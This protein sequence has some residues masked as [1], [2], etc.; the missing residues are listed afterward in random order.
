MIVHAS[1]VR[2]LVDCGRPESWTI[3]ARINAYNARHPGR[4]EGV[5]ASIFFIN[6]FSKQHHRTQ[7]RNTT[8]KWAPSIRNLS[9]SVF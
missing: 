8:A 4:G 2:V 9:Q 3:M 7:L 5:Q 1:G 6:D